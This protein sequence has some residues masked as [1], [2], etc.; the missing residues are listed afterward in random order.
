M[1]GEKVSGVAVHT[2]ARVMAAAGDDEILVSGAVSEALPSGEIRLADRGVHELNG[3]PGEWRL[4]R[5][6]AVGAPKV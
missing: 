4:F 6:E 1:R 3:V 5:L 2:A